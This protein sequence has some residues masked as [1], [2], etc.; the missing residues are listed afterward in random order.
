MRNAHIH[1]EREGGRE[2]ERE[3]EQYLAE[4]QEGKLET[5]EFPALDVCQ[6]FS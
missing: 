3:N 2:R 4:Q 6:L 1:R 5:D